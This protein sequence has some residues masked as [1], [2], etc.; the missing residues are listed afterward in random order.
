M[1][2]SLA[3]QAASAI[4]R[5]GHKSEGEMRLTEDTNSRFRGLA[6]QTEG[7]IRLTDNPNLRFAPVV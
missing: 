3:Q 1:T 4:L 7:E 5:F 6:Q 2:V